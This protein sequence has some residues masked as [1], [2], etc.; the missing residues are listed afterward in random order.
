M[1]NS[2]SCY[3]QIAFTKLQDIRTLNVG[4]VDRRR[5]YAGTAPI[6]TNLTVT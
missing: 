2:I 4:N 5:V 6:F 1:P 3:M